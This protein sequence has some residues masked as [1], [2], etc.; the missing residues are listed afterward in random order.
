MTDNITS[1]N[2]HP[3]SWITL[4]LV[5]LERKKII[6][7]SYIWN[8]DTYICILYAAS[9]Y[10]NVWNKLIYLTGSGIKPFDV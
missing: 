3:S 6:G 7:Y 8:S 4:Y 9:S 5:H 1:Q 2:I 10:N